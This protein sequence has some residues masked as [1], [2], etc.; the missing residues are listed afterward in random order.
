MLNFPSDLYILQSVIDTL[1][2]IHELSLIP[3]ADGITITP[4]AV[5]AALEENTALVS[6]THVAFKSAFMYDM[7]CVA[8]LIHQGGGLILLDLSHSVGAVPVD[9]NG[10]NVDLAVGYTYK[11]LN[12]GTGSPAF[13]YVRGDLQAQLNQPMWG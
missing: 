5:E 1:G 9:L 12:G 10:C 2:K 7:A 6:L 8:D 3:S 4:E 11:Y 13:L